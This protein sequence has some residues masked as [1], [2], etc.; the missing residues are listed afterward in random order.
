MD[1]CSSFKVDNWALCILPRASTRE[2]YFR[3]Y[4]AEAYNTTPKLFEWCLRSGLNQRDLDFQS[5]ALPAELHKHMKMID[6]A[7]STLHRKF[8]AFTLFASSSNLYNANHFM[9]L[10]GGIEPPTS[11]LSEWRSDR[12]SYRS[13][14]GGP[15]R[16]RT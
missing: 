5:S 12:L 2:A 3:L 15:P 6:S 13:I 1:R 7:G 10:L 8:L 14:Y 11:T 4:S 9:V 16:I